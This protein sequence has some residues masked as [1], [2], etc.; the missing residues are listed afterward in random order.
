[1]SSNFV[2]VDRAQQYLFP[3]SI[4]D[5]LPE[6]HLARFVVD[7]VSQLDLRPLVE[8]YAGNGVKAHHPQVLLSLLFYGYATGIFSSR[9]IERATYDSIA[10]RY[11]SANTHPDHDTIATFRKRFLEHLN[12][13]FKQILLLAHEM[14][15]LKLGK[16]SLDG[17]KIKA[18]ASRHHALSWDY[19]NKLEQQLQAEVDELMC[20]AEKADSENI[21]DGMDIPEEL[22]RRQDRL[23]A[24][25]KAKEQIEQRAA[26]RYDQ[27]QHEYEKKVAARRDKAEE[28]GKKPRGR[29]PK[30]P[31]SGP[32]KND[33]VNLTDEESRIMPS[34]NKGFDSA[35]NAQTAVDV[36]TMIIVESHVSQAA[37][38][39]QEI[40][41]AL[42]ALAALPAQLGQVE[43]LLA[44]AGYYSED[45]VVSCAQSQIEAFIPPG[46]M[47]H[48][49]PLGERFA[50]PA[51]LPENAK[52]I[53][54]MRHKLKTE[55]GR[56][57]YAKRKSTVE[58]VFG[59]IKHVLGFRQFFLR[60]LKA[61][62]GEW[63]LVSIAWNIKRMFALKG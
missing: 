36:A 58:P 7:I 37:N 52:P 22:S 41:P 24:I 59:I 21:P 31:E 54:E 12:P 62:T 11:V 5:W 1:M 28:T 25:A 63:T 42:V 45:N 9:K 51:P 15:F 53:D 18:N 16:V 38:D 49:Q 48:N 3:P 2:P 60:G 44:D 32:R 19:A 40:A 26:K 4:Q 43:A 56:A 61:V 14:G 17:T 57:V 47:G 30:P 33:Q 23:D 13:L 6:N 50:Q 39:K 27:E 29:E 46:R 20:L 35:Y 10:F 8:T 34:S 55:E